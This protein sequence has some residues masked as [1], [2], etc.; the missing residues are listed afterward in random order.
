M[1]N[2]IVQRLLIFFIGLPAIIGLVYFNQ[3]NHA[4]LH[5]I[6][7]FMSFMGANE[8]YTLLSKKF[9]L[10]PKPL[11]LAMNMIPPVFSAVCAILNIN[12]MFGDFNGIDFSFLAAIMVCMA[13]EVLAMKTFENALSHILTS[14]FIVLYTG[15]F[16]TFLSRMTVYNHSREYISIFLL[17]VFLCDSAAWF[18]GNLFGKN[19]KGFIKASPNKS[20]A[21]FCGGILG[22]IASGII[23]WKFCPQAFSAPLGYII[24]FGFTIS[25][26]SI[27]GDLFESVIK[28][29]VKT[30][31]SGTLIPGRGGVLDSID[32]IVFAVPMFYLG[33][34][35]LFITPLAM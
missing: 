27:L 12:T 11:V 21:G 25:I 17:M 22:S 31:D 20:I 8:L 28:W 6:I 32:S 9:K 13:Y 23:G 34:N 30:K 16:I 18:F 33:I 19:N 5:V 7:V 3:L 1:N 2:K 35:F 10:Q 26:F 24:I 14:V 4:A 29:S 15:F